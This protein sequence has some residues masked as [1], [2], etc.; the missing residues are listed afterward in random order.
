[1]CK[2]EIFS[3]ILQSFSLPHRKLLLLPMP[4]FVVILLFD[5]ISLKLPLY[6]PNCRDQGKVLNCVHKTVGYDLALTIIA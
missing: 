2:E 5:E 3:L 1:M 6:F 4:F